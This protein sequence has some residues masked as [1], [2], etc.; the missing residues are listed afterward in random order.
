MQKLIEKE[1]LEDKVFVDSAGTHGWHEGESPDLRS[2]ECARRHG[3]DISYIRSRPLIEDDFL[4]F[5]II[6]VSDERNLRDIRLVYPKG[7]EYKAR[8]G[9][10]LEYAPDWGDNVADPYY[11]DGFDDVFMMIEDACKNL[12]EE[13]KQGKI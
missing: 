5:D 7:N 10:I 4:T 3:V 8:L 2:V 9:K 13:I 11:N 1:G 6:L 12:L